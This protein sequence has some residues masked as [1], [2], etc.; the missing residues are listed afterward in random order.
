M[1]KRAVSLGRGCFFLRCVL[2][3]RNKKSRQK[4]ISA[5]FFY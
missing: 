5:G 4:S 2:A 1:M 3:D